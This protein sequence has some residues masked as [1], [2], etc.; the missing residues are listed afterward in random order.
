MKLFRIA[1]VCVCSLM[2]LSCTTKTSKSRK[3][4]KAERD[5]LLSQITEQDQRL[6]ELQ[7]CLDL[8]TTSM[9]SIAAQE[10]ILFLPDPENPDKPLNPKQL[11]ERLDALSQLIAR[12]HDRISALEDSLDT[13]NDYLLSLKRL[14][15]NYKTQIQQKDAEIFTMKEELKQRDASIA[16]LRGRVNKMEAEIKTKDSDIDFLL[17]VSDQQQKIMTSQDNILNEGYYLVMSKKELAALGIKSGDIS[18][19]NITLADFTKVDI[20]DFAGMSISTDRVKILTQMPVSSYQ[21]TKN[22]DGTTDLQVLSAADFWQY[23]NILII[24]TR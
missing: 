22:S 24:Q 9:D 10:Q 17:N 20:R 6:A 7:S 3:E 15:A 21:L 2:V 19:S 16:S 18:K 4:L 23:S 12:Q 1:A 13:Q 14:V 8:L 11:N 5:T